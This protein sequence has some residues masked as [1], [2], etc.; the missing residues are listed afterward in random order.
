MSTEEALIKSISGVFLF[1]Q[2]GKG[3]FQR[4]WSGGQEGSGTVVVTD[5][6]IIFINAKGAKERLGGGPEVESVG[7]VD[8]L[9]SAQGGVSVPF[10]MISSATISGS[11][12]AGYAY[13]KGAYSDLT[14]RSTNPAQEK[15]LRFFGKET[16]AEVLRLLKPSKKAP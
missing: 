13:G 9:L 5:S 16:A 14:I 6:R 3:F 7:K 4:L 12:A 10:S 11:G 8:K 15:T 2:E 1:S